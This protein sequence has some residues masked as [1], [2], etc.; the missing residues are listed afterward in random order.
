[1]KKLEYIQEIFFFLQAYFFIK[2]ARI[3]PVKGTNE[4]VIV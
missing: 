4:A 3:L 1:M 2:K